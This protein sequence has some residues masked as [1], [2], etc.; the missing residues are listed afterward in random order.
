MTERMKA[1]VNTMATIMMIRDRTKRMMVM[2]MMMMMLMMMIMM[3]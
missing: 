1:M 3:R 2:M